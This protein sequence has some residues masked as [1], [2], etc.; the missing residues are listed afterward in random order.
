MDLERD[1]EAGERAQAIDCAEA[2]PTPDRR[3]VIGCALQGFRSAWRE[4]GSFRKHVFGVAA[5]LAML[6]ALKPAAIWWAIALF[7]S[8]VLLALELVNSAIERTIDHVDARL[9]PRIRAI[10]DMSAAA[11]IAASIGVFLLGIIMILDTLFWPS[12]P[13]AAQ[14]S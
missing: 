12:A 1:R 3:S 13:P 10:K 11:V 6:V 7:C 2:T 14:E 8:A 5:M 4:E 9:H